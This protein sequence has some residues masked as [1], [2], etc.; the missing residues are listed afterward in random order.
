MIRWSRADRCIL[1]SYILYDN[2]IGR[3]SR[4]VVGGHENRY[5]T[6]CNT[7]CAAL[8]GCFRWRAS[9]IRGGHWD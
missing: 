6:C 1:H 2:R 5:R 7:L 8:V 3:D 9:G 4:G